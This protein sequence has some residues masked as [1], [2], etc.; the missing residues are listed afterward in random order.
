MVIQNKQENYK[1]SQS[2]TQLFIN[3]ST[4]CTH[5]RMNEVQQPKLWII[6]LI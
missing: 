1:D 2:H 5:E 3:F 6:K 4:K